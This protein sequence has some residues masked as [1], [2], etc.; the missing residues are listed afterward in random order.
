MRFSLIL[1]MHFTQMGKLL[2]KHSYQMKVKNPLRIVAKVV[3]KF[4]GQKHE[5]TDFITSFDA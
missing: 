1:P 5:S 2:S 4:K 3:K